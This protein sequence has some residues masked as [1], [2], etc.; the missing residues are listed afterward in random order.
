MRRLSRKTYSPTTRHLCSASSF[1]PRLMYILSIQN[2]PWRSAGSVQICMRDAMSY[3]RYREIFKGGIGRWKSRKP[4]TR[5]RF[6]HTTMSTTSTTTVSAQK[7]AQDKTR[8]SASPTSPPRDVSPKP[9]PPNQLQ[10]ASRPP[11]SGKGPQP[12]GNTA[13]KKPDN[14]S[15][16]SNLPPAPVPPE[17]SLVEVIGQTFPPFDHQRLIVGPFTEETSRDTRFEEEL[18]A[19]LLDVLLETHAWAA[20]RPKYGSQITVQKLEQKIGDVIEVEKDQGM[21]PTLRP[22][23]VSRSCSSFILV[24]SQSLPA[25]LFGRR[26]LESWMFAVLSTRYPQFATSI[27]IDAGIF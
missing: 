12:S 8:S 22:T 16:K 15:K 6:F 2:C 19:M 14:P 11:S 21:S 7:P 24:M 25:L 23:L 26:H 10:V 18:G 17:S 20:A 1:L 4:P 3:Q 13:G 9:S 5:R 27:L